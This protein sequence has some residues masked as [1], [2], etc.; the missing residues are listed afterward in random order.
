MKPKIGFLTIGQKDYISEASF[1]FAE[2]GVKKIRNEG[3]EVVFYR[4]SLTDMVTAQNEAKKIIKEDTDGI[5]IFLETWI[6]CPVAMAAIRM[7]EHL[8]FL[9]WGF[10][11]FTDEKG[12]KDM[13]G[14]FVAYSAL[15]GSLDR[16]GYNYKKVVGMPDDK[17]VL[18]KV[19]SF[20]RSA[21]TYRKLKE[22]RVG[23]FGYTSMGM[24]PGNFDHLLLRRYIGPEVIHF[25]TYQ[26]IE[27]MKRVDEKVCLE[28]IKQLK[29][30]IEMSEFVKENQLIMAIKMYKALMNITKE[31]SLQAVTIKCQY[32]LSKMVGMTACI[33]LS[34]ASDNGIV[35]GCEGDIPTLVT[36]VIFNNI[37]DQPI[38]YG[39]ALDIENK[40]ILFS[41]C[42]LAPFSLATKRRKKYIRNFNELSGIISSQ[43]SNKPDEE[44]WGGI[45][46]IL[47]SVTLKPGTVTFGRLVEGIGSYKFVY[48][49]GEGIESELRN[50]VMPAIS[51]IIDGSI[52]K[53]VETLPSQHYSLCYGD[54]SNE[55]EDLCRILNIEIIRI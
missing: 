12:N 34:L 29:K 39:D 17:E 28:T 22:S 30:E 25:D 3:I 55:I 15:T 6:E 19:N 2:E 38:F 50:G 5:I 1:K 36:Q 4:K 52:E 9:I 10:Q 20:C 45:N 13:T 46:G 43:D 32:E 51:V 11:M 54:I 16:V 33:P 47:C 41:P 26:L 27:E 18:S 44:K 23:L 35:S 37:T 40:E 48:G 24:Y 42:G 21:S 8:P 7:I 31:F 53:F 49:I 14:S